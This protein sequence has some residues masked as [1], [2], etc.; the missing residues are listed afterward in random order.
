MSDSAKGTFASLLDGTFG[1]LRHTWKTTLLCGGIAF[2]PAAALYGWAYDR[3]FASMT[4]VWADEGGA[5]FGYAA[6][7]GPFALIL[8][9][10]LVQGLALLFVR[11]FVTAQAAAALR[12]GSL[13]VPAIVGRVFRQAGARLVGQRILQGLIYIGLFAAAMIVL[14]IAAAF[15][16]DRPVRKPHGV[17]YVLFPVLG[18]VLISYWIWR[19]IATR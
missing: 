5:P 19:G 2:L 4:G 13:S 16:T 11:S 3:L 6:L 1:Q 14:V 8:L 7:I 18:A 10:A 12:G 15:V 17:W 9:A